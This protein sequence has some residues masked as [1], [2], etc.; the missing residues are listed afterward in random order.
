MN[1]PT[2][3]HIR[4]R[5]AGEIEASV[6]R[7]ILEGA[8]PGGARLP[9]V[10]SL[11]T[12]LGVSAA[13]V[14]SAYRDLR[15]RGLIVAAGRLGTT[16]AERGPVAPRGRPTF[17]PGVRD[18]S[19]GNPD[20]ALL[21]DL[22]PHLRRIT[23]GHV[24]YGAA[25]NDPDLLRLAA[26]RF[27]AD[28]VMADN[29]TVVGGALDGVERVLAAHLR[30]GDRVAVEDPSYAGVTD[31][32]RSLGLMP[33]AAP[34]D[35]RGA[36]P[37][38]LEA[39][40]HGGVAA[41][42]LTPRAQNPYGSELDA[43]RAAE[44][45]AVLRRFPDA[46]LIEDDHASEISERPRASVSAG[47]AVTRHWAQV[48]SVSKSLG[49]DLRLAVLTGDATTAARVEGR[50]LLGAGWVS[51]LVQRLVVSLWS[52]PETERVLAA[53]REAYARRRCGLLDALRAESIQAHG[54]SGLNVWIPVAHEDATV[55]ALLDRGWGVLAGERFRIAAPR[56][57]RVTT[58]T[59]E[60][61]EAR[62]FTAD[63]RQALAPAPSR[64]V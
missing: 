9:T 34:V 19:G 29:L 23:A 31:L 1:V 7:G 49:P 61:E 24:L 18:L 11:A 42:V 32:V 22:E 17:S 43:G 4:G 54:A 60:P 37:R 50:R 41:C 27:E 3:Y 13:T 26:S 14:A 47:R 2:R 36:D 21:P 63:L 38:A 28:G 10:R 8:L 48:R 55:A 56:A 46:L 59:L 16:V 64:L 51:H 45:R 12:R 6:E 58:A 5:R 25:A 62:R 15:R 30:P 39:V 57:I 40:L 20:P 44:L 35:D 52:D 53:A 33:V